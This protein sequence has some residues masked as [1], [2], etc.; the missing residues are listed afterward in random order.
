MY[1][2]EKTTKKVVSRAIV[3]DVLIP[4]QK[5]QVLY[6]DVMYIEHQHFLVSVYKPLQLTI[7]YRIE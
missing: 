4:D 7:Q 3:D 1:V 5:R 2:K 6:A